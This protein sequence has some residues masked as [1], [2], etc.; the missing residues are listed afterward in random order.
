MWLQCSCRKCPAGPLPGA[1]MEAAGLAL[2]RIVRDTRPI[3]C[4]LRHSHPTVH[5]GLWGLWRAYHIS[6]HAHNLLGEKWGKTAETQCLMWDDPE[7]PLPKMISPDPA[8]LP[9]VQSLPSGKEGR[10]KKNQN[11]FK[12]IV[13]FPRSGEHFLC[14]QA[15]TFPSL[16]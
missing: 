4:P 3:L 11:W 5:T 16:C 15:P 7:L 10:L 9:D 1:P 12:F 14:M 13:A 2:G 8:H 6:F